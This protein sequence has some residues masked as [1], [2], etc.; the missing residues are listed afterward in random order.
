MS[1]LAGYDVIIEM[2]R[3]T[4]KDM[5][6][7]EPIK[8]SNGGTAY[9]FGG[10]F[11]LYLPLQMNGFGSGHFNTICEVSFEAITRSQNCRIKMQLK[12]ASIQFGSLII[13]RVSGEATAQVP[14]FVGT[15]PNTPNNP[16]GTPI[17]YYPGAELTASTTI[18]MFN[19]D[20]GT[21]HRVKTQ[22]G[23]SASDG[24]EKAIGFALDYW[25][26]SQGDK[27]SDKFSVQVVPG[28]DSRNPNQL[29]AQPD[30]MWIDEDTLGIFGY[31]RKDA[32]GGNRFSKFDSDIHQTQDEYLYVDTRLFGSVPVPAK[33]FSVLISPAGFEQTIACPTIRNKFAREAVKEREK[34][35][36][37]EE[38]RRKNP[39]STKDER[40][41]FFAYYNEA[42]AK[43]SNSQ[44]AISVN[45]SP[46]DDPANSQ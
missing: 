4:I 37:M 45:L 43:G 25:L 26:R 42:I 18:F 14:I 24:L 44:E 38:E 8:L 28:K 7:H 23:A 20:D 39:D 3:H 33:R 16:S 12:S 34:P 17:Q 9:L 29:S 46:F 5:I 35:R 19:T 15:Q 31:Y 2:A 30:L 36:F 32:F 22:I 13:K 27:L 10:P 21:K 41:N 11:S 6:N 40:Q 1:N